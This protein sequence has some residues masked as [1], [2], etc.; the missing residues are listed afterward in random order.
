MKINGTNDISWQIVWVLYLNFLVLARVLKPLKPVFS[1]S[2]YL[3]YASLVYADS[4]VVA[5]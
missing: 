4:I 1:I 2:L 3:Q 5:V